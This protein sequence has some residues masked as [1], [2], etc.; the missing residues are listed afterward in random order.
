M[1]APK[2]TRAVAKVETPTQLAPK[3]PARRKAPQA[4]PTR[5]DMTKIRATPE[6]VDIN[7][8]KPY[9]FNARDNR[10]AVKA[11]KASIEQFGFLVPIVIGEDGSLA[12]GH[13]RI[14]AAKELGMPEVLALRASH[15][16]TEQ[17]DAF[18]LIDNKVA[19]IATWDTDLLAPELKRLTD[20]GF[21]FT[22]F[23][24][25]QE[26]IDCM[27]SVVA[28]DCL[29]LTDL[30]A[31]ATQEEQDD[32]QTLAGRRGPQSTRMVLGDLTIFV[33]SEAFNAWSDGVRR[34]H[35][36]NKAEVEAEILNRLGILV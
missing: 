17:I 10:E 5:V 8:V 20:F 13:T 25:T 28:A 27:S 32:G 9:E 14:E 3:A 6:W 26:E 7:D 22:S 21:N 36:F 23:G 35:N 18:R 34:M 31:P 16:T 11:V 4:A 1:V 19:E 12:A 29:S 15:L 33:P 30:G 2:R 24:W